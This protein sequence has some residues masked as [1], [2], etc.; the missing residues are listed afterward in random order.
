MYLF[1]KNRTV[2]F[3][4]KRLIS[5]KRKKIHIIKI[6]I[7]NYIHH[8]NINHN[9]LNSNEN[10]YLF[11]LIPKYKKFMNNDRDKINIMLL[12][13]RELLFHKTF[14]H[15][16]DIQAYWKLEFHKKIKDLKVLSVLDPFSHS[17]FNYEFQN[18]SLNI[19]K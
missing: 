10:E 19:Q 13:N 3:K 7:D 9:F 8:I 12:K 1:S 2:F 4:F 16:K 5:L 14:N 6:S 18:I 17:I 11:I 15:Y